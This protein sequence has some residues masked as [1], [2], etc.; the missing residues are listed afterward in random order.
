MG[1]FIGLIVAL[2]V[3]AA[4][5][6][7]FKKKTLSLILAVAIF[8]VGVLSSS[9]IMIPTG[10]TGIISTFGK[11]NEHKVL[12]AGPNIVAPWQN[13]IKMNNQVQKSESKFKCFSSDLQETDVV[14][15]VGYKINQASAMQI[16][17]NI[18]KH[19]VDV[20]VN[21]QI[22]EIV[23]NHIGKYNAEEL[24][25]SREIVQ[26]NIYNDLSKSLSEYN[27]I[28]DYFSIVDIDFTDVFT[29]AVEAK[30]EAEQKAKQAI[31]EANR[32][33]EEA[34]YQADI[35]VINATAAAEKQKLAADAELYAAQQKAE[36]NRVL[37][38]SLTGSLLEYYEIM[39]V[40]S[41][42]DGKLPEIYG[43]DGV[44][45]IIGEK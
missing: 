32:K 39:N 2:L 22:Y 26:A 14:I 4:S 19:Y 15:N 6:I 11:I 35:D 27:V 40:D 30:S 17:K 38:E 5:L 33:K 9:I 24:I 37:N 18:G 12:S 45:P 28:L 21:P 1:I 20:V 16:Y 41:R 31:I 8:G 36:A 42:W 44:M 23:K 25:S 43:A 10:Y 29:N 7:K 13:V 3:G 34:Q